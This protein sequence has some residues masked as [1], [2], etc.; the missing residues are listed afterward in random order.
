M[1]KIRFYIAFFISKF[2]QLLLKILRRNATYFPGKIAIK[3]CPNF[4]KFIDKPSK[5]IAVTGTNGK[6][7]VC[8]IL[9]D[10]LENNG[11]L[12][13][14]NKFGSNVNSGIASAFLAN[15]GLNN[16][17][18]K[19]IAVLEVDE[20]SSILIYKYVKPDYLVC[21]NLFRDSIKRN[22]NTDFIVDVINSALPKE[23]KLILNA[24]DLI[25]CSLGK[26]NEKIYFGIDKLDT[27][28]QETNNIIKDI[29]TCP[30]CDAKL[31]YEYARYHHIGKAYCPNCDFKSPKADYLVTS[32]DKENKEIIVSNN[33]KAFKYHI[34][35]DSIFNIY[36]VISVITILRQIG[37]EEEK[38][39]DSLR[40][41]KILESRLNEDVIN[42]IQVIT[43]MA[44]RENPVAASRVFDYVKSQTGNKAIIILMDDD[45]DAV[46]SSENTTWIYDADFELL[47]DDLIKQVIVGGVR[48][49]DYYLRLLIAGVDREKI[50]VIEDE[51]KTVD[52]LKKDNIDKIF[53]LHDMN[54]YKIA[55][56]LKEKLRGNV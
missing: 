46:K 6:T 32:I 21:T 48:N 38:I 16:K 27:D 28:V 25:S 22:A 9:S 44:K 1:E 51:F 18:K 36:N 34:I 54:K 15:T 47:N 17:T 5:I 50:N 4:L 13:L 43:H 12:I 19:Q 39:N 20:R 55:L 49:N 35:S 2:V 30:I 23:T 11:Y 8:N 33:G 31:K 42:G 29:K 3:I 41:T 7:T 10:I 26:E 37:I 14:N 24:D 52:L 53:I 45:H 40:K 56:K